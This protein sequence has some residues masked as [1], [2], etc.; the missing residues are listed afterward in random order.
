MNKNGWCE[1]IPRKKN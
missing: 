1:E